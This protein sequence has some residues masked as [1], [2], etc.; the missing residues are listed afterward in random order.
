MVRAGA[1]HIWMGIEPP[2]HLL[3]PPPSQ[4][5]PVFPLVQVELGFLVQLQLWA[6]PAQGKKGWMERWG[7]GRR[8]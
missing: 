7:W 8:L 6:F 1:G 5:Q 4:C 3:G 2:P